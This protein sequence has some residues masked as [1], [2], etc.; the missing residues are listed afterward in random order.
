[1]VASVSDGTVFVEGGTF[2]MGS[3]ESYPEERPVREA[4]AD[5]LWIDEHP[6]TPG[7]LEAS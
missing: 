1:M 2:R 7:L 3:A 4:H 6:V 5:G